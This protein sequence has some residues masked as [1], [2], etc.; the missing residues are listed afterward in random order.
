MNRPETSQEPTVQINPA[1][2]IS[3]KVNLE[4]MKQKFGIEFVIVNKENTEHFND[5]KKTIGCRCSAQKFYEK[6]YDRIVKQMQ[7]YD[8]TDDNRTGSSL[9]QPPTDLFAESYGDERIPGAT[10]SWLEAGSQASKREE[11]EEFE[12]LEK[13]VSYDDFEE[14]SIPITEP[15]KVQSKPEQFVHRSTGRKIVTETLKRHVEEI[16]SFPGTSKLLK[17]E[18][19]EMITTLE[20]S[21]EYPDENWPESSFRRVKEGEMIFKKARGVSFSDDSEMLSLGSEREADYDYICQYMERCLKG[22][23]FGE[24]AQMGYASD[25]TKHPPSLISWGEEEEISKSDSCEDLSILE[26]YA[27]KYMKEHKIDDVFKY[28]CAQLL[29][30]LPGS[31]RDGYFLRFL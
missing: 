2:L 30:N 12:S 19:A 24:E 5:P 15:L 3:E 4:E 25:M 17:R 13:V 20:E 29:V 28:F 7:I 22:A 10:E 23:D 26:K 31:M 9:T 18:I 11:S 8:E 6:Y 1:K 14:W 16:E 27:R 21:L